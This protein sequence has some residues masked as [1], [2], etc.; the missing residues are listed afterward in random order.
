MSRVKYLLLYHNDI[1]SLHKSNQTQVMDH[2]IT[3][4]DIGEEIALPDVKRTIS[5]SK[6]NRTIAI[7]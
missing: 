3:K 6:D 5:F 2:K 7:F 1:R 4:V